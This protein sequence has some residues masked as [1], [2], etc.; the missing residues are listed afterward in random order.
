MCKVAI[1]ETF[2]SRI[3]IVMKWNFLSLVAQVF[4]DEFPDMVVQVHLTVLL[5]QASL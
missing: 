5:V 1:N 2:S 4:A 3:S